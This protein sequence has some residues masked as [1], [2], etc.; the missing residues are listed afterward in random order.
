M[1][2]DSGLFHGMEGLMEKGHNTVIMGILN[3][4]PDSFFDGGTYVD[5]AAAV[6]RAQEMLDEGAHWIDVGG[7]SS[8][9][10]AVPVGAEEE[11][12]RIIPVI[13]ALATKGFT[14]SVDTTKAHVAMLALEAGASIINDISA[15][16]M[17]RDM[18]AMCARYNACSVLMH[19]RGTPA[20]MQSDTEYADV[21]AE[22]YSYLEQ[23]LEYA[24]ECGMEREN[25]ILDPGIGF[26]KSAEGNIELI[27]NI[28]HF[29][30][31]GCPVLIGAS[32]KSFIGAVTGDARADRLS[33][34]LAAATAAVLNGVD[35]LRVHDV[36]ETKR[37]VLVAEAI[38][39]KGS[40]APLSL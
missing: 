3:V 21:V 2:L 4:T 15:F 11:A 40:A 10:G 26:G 14:L 6:S 32:R 36:A 38:A 16:S 1:S 28:A 13:K 23:R 35:V 5:L 24:V 7:E 27:R 29:K 20:T 34:S 37:A 22:V 17:D 30:R 18:A 33:G 19:R 31:L 8:R 9:P 39:G 25:I 12:A